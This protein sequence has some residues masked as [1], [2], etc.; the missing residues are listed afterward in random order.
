VDFVVVAASPFQGLRELMQKL[1]LGHTWEL[2]RG[3]IG[4]W[5]ELGFVEA[6]RRNFC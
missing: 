1:I 6:T 5:I 3:S 2:R 4:A